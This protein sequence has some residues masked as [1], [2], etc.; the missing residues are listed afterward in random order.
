MTS[1]LINEVI[2]M[3]AV[4]LGEFRV[5]E[6]KVE[7]NLLIT[8]ANKRLW[9]TFES[10]LKNTSKYNINEQDKD[11]NTTLHLLVQENQTKYLNQVLNK[12]ANVDIK[13]KK[14]NTPMDLAFERDNVDVVKI[15]MDSSSLGW[16]QSIKAKDML[17]EAIAK[18]K[19]ELATY[20]VQK[21]TNLEKCLVI[22]KCVEH[23]QIDILKVM[24]G[25]KKFEVNARNKDGHTPLQLAVVKGYKLMIDI[26]IKHGADVEVVD[27]K[28]R[29]LL[30]LALLHQQTDTA[31]YLVEMGGDI[32]QQDEEG[33]TCLHL[34][35]ESNYIRLVRLLINSGCNA[36][37]ADHDDYLPI[38]VMVC[39]KRFN[40]ILW[41]VIEKTGN[42][43]AQNCNG[44]TPLHCAFIAGNFD[45]VKILLKKGADPSILNNVK[46]PYTFDE[47]M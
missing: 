19:P 23:N 22:H 20:F 17:S 30:H 42:V 5:M 14:N 33:S 38:H 13:N 7:Q 40:I 21:I 31:M 3:F 35:I 12:G 16:E 1:Y 2:N 25:E 4:W 37:I 29:N 15:L 24:L 18:G 27:H 47:C 10:M 34:A 32:D 26:L 45:A 41:D 9:N 46:Q 39:N 43:N 8:A 28:K 6:K 36:R 11:G 44:D